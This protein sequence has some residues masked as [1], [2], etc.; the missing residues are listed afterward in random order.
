[1]LQC[2]QDQEEKEDFTVGVGWLC[3]ASKGTAMERGAGE[4]KMAAYVNT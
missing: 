2:V 4:T 1:M 3:Q